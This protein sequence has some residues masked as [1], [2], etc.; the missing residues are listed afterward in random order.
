MS[1]VA[2]NPPAGPADWTEPRWEF[3]RPGT[4]MTIATIFHRRQAHEDGA[5]V[6][7]AAQAYAAKQAERATTAGAA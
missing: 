7:E 2:A 3:A 5:W 4:G 1:P 6:R